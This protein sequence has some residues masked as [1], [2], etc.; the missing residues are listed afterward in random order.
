MGIILNQPCIGFGHAL[1][2]DLKRQLHHHA[3]LD[4]LGK[5][6]GVLQHKRIGDFAADDAGGEQLVVVFPLQEPYVQLHVELFF[7][8]LQHGVV[9]FDGIGIVAGQ[10]GDGEFLRRVSHVLAQVHFRQRGNGAHRQQQ[11]QKQG[12]QLLHG[13]S[14]FF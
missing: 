6:G 14:S 5:L 12:Y 2:H 3:L 10:P 7:Q 1:L 9:L 11:R 4:I 8:P 13:S